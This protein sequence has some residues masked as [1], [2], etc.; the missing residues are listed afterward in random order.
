MNDSIC[1]FMPDKEYNGNIKIVNFV[2]EADFKN[3]E[4]PFF[5]PV[6]LVHLIT[7][8][9]GMLKTD[10]GSF[11]LSA[12]SIFFAFPGCFYEIEANDEFQYMY[13]SFTGECVQTM[14]EKLGISSKKPV[15][16]DF[17]NITEFWLKAIRRVNPTNA[18]ILPESVLL[19]TLSFISDGENQ[20][21]SQKNTE[22]FTSTI[23]EY[24]N[25]HYTDADISLKQIAG[26]FS[27]SQK[28]VSFLFKKIT[29][30]GFNDY[31]NHLRIQHALS[32]IDDSMTS[33]TQISELCGYSDPL[34][35]SKVFKKKLGVSPTIY[36]QQKTSNKGVIK[37]GKKSVFLH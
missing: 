16:Y 32:L 5:R 13:I 6:Y 4:Q 2:Y 36:I 12:G 25:L 18:N 19:Y 9:S 33:I 37:N 21:F 1:R 31:V 24:I 22:N 10:T 15:F 26:I 35:F 11:E 8:G 14:L 28:Y 27:Y 17:D 29:N 20:T 30:V 7:K 23:V 34:Y 3:L